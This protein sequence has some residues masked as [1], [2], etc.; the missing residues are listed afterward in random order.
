VLEKVL[1]AAKRGNWVVVE[2]LQ[3]LPEGQVLKLF[4]FLNDRLVRI[5]QQFNNFKVWITLLVSCPEFEP[6]SIRKPLPSH[7]S[8]LTNECYKFFIDSAESAKQLMQLAYEPSLG[9]TIDEFERVFY[10]TLKTQEE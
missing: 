9:L 10:Q 2:N 7:L 5:R 8:V 4:K 1:S 3:E 6:L